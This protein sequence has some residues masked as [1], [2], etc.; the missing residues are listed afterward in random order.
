MQTR[1]ARLI[2]RSN[3]SCYEICENEAITLHDFAHRNLDRVTEARAI[4][5]ERMEFAVFPA[6]VDPRRQVGQKL[7][8]EIPSGKFDGQNL[9]IDAGNLRFQAR[10]NH[11]G[12]ELP[13][14]DLPDWEQG[15]KARTRQLFLA[16]SANVGEKKIAE[17]HGFDTLIDCPGAKIA[18]STL[19]LFIGTGPGKGNGPERHAQRLGLQLQ[20][21]APDGVH[22]HSI[23]LFVEGGDERYDFN[24]GV[25]P[26][27]MQRPGA[28]FTTG[29]RKCNPHTALSRGG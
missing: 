10:S 13:G 11:L 12:S 19:V 15:F 22:G 7:Q 20:Q 18:H 4:V 9:R 25:L 2:V 5:N 17:R 8:V 28:I 23:E 16:I 26:E 3:R 27:E 6:R 29:P 14:R 1:R 24:R 21:F